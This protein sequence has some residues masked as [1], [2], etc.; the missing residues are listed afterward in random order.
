MKGGEKTKI[1]FECNCDDTPKRGKSAKIKPSK[2][3]EPSLKNM[4]RD[5]LRR[6][7]S[8]RFELNNDQY[9][10]NT[11]FQAIKG[12]KSDVAR[13]RK[14]LQ[15]LTL[16]KLQKIARSKLI[17]ITRNKDDKTVYCKKSTIVKKLC[18]KKYGK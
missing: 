18:D 15:G 1:V 14:Y 11:P 10:S 12:G 8:K 16:Q 2:P 4:E 3:S 6:S 9:I 17:K 13:Y 7:D 5:P